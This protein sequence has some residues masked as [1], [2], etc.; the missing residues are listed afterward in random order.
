MQ[1]WRSSRSLRCANAEPVRPCERPAGRPRR[2]V[3]C[4][5]GASVHQCRLT[6]RSSGAP[7]AGHQGPPAVRSIVCRRALASRRWRPLNSNVRRRLGRGCGYGKCSSVRSHSG[8]GS[9]LAPVHSFKRPLCSG[10]AASP[11]LPRAAPRACS[12]ACCNSLLGQTAGRC[13]GG[14]PRAVCVAPTDSR[15]AQ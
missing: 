3:A 14:A 2:A 1:W 15:F 4:W 7:T 5:P 9:R 11:R 13:S 12:L 6:C 8:L 10:T